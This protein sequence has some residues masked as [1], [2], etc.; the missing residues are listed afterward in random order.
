[1]SGVDARRRRAPVE[2]IAH[3]RGPRLYLGGLRV[4]HGSAALVAA[5]ILAASNHRLWAAAALG[6]CAHD[7]RDFP[8]RDRDN[9]H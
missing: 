1:M 9:R 4:H 5:L 8:W 3:P 7:A 2:L 6:I